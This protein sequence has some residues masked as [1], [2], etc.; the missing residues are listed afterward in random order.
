MDLKNMVCAAAG[1]AVSGMACKGFGGKEMK[2]YD[3][4]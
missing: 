4:N 1:A 3:K 2:I